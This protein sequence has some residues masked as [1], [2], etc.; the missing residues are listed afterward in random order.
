MAA[1]GVRANSSSGFDF[2]MVKQVASPTKDARAPHPLHHRHNPHRTTA[3]P[4]A[5]PLSPASLSADS[6]A[7]PAHGRPSST[8]SDWPSLRAISC[9]ESAARR[10]HYQ[11]CRP[12]LLD[13][14]LGPSEQAYVSFVDKSNSGLGHIWRTRERFKWSHFADART[15][16]APLLKPPRVLHRP[17]SPYYR[18]H[19]SPLAVSLPVHH[20]PRRLRISTK[21]LLAGSFASAN[22]AG[23][24]IQW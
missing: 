21:P 14:P 11:Q 6:P 4:V 3:Y 12:S 16:G 24:C 17:T 23:T 5:T 8:Q 7:I 22:V 19:P 13:P 2:S 9:A 1:D 20:R 18:R 10:L 15:G